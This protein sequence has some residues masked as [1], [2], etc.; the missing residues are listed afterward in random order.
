M[1]LAYQEDVISAI[2][3]STKAQIGYKGR[4]QNIQKNHQ[5]IMAK[6]QICEVRNDSFNKEKGMVWYYLNLVIC[7]VYKRLQG[8]QAIQAKSA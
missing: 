4:K 5:L 6:K 8:R 2:Q 3:F 1:D 7:M